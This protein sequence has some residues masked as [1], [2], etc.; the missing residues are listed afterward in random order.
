M[1][2]W[3]CKH[4]FLVRNNH[5]LN[6]V[7]CF[8]FFKKKREQQM[9]TIFRILNV[10]FLRQNDT[11]EC[12]NAPPTSSNRERKMVPFNKSP[13]IILFA[14]IFKSAWWVK[15]KIWI[16]EHVSFDSQNSIE[17]HCEYFSAAELSESGSSHHTAS[18]YGASSNLRYS[19]YEY[20]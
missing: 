12:K 20:L 10:S 3:V 1:Q 11:N 9:D 8:E 7:N 15:S 4:E 2:K 14:S 18:S 16:A 17:F 13:L 6:F 5:L 19:L